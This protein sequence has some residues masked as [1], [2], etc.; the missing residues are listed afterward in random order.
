MNI[1]YYS[2]DELSKKALAANALQEDIN[3][4]G[5]WF[6]RF[7]S[8]YWNGE[9]FE[10]DKNNRLFPIQQEVEEDIWETIGY[11]IR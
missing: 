11:E 6:E 8:D 10:I 3:N 1:N 2:Y 7:G 5:E 4:L 9:Y